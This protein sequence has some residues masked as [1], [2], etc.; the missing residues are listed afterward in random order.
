MMISIMGPVA[1]CALILRL[2]KI[3]KYRRARAC[4]EGNLPDRLQDGSLLLLRVEWLLAQPSDW[5]L[6]RRQDMP[7]EAF[8]SPADALRLLKESKVAALSYR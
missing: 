5:I 1:A 2:V 6:K 4:I 7:E 8:W 3:E